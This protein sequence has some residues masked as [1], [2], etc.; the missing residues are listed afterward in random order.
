MADL[1]R[2]LSEGRAGRLDRVGFLAELAQAPLWVPVVPDADGGAPS[3]W[4]F[5]WQDS[6][7][8]A[9]FSSAALLDAFGEVPAHVEV[10]GAQ[11]AATW[12][13]D[14]A[15][16]LDPGSPDG[17]VLPGTVVVTVPDAGPQVVAA[18][19]TVYVGE[20]ASAP[21]P[22]FGTALTEAAQA[23]PGVVQAWLVQLYEERLGPR[24]VGGVQLHEGADPGQVMP[25][26][27]EAVTRALPAEQDLDLVALTGGL[28]AT[29]QAQLVPLLPT[30]T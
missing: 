6:P 30:A 2:A 19:S 9:A 18:G 1:A 10:T 15:L 22:F 17:L 3:L 12:S 26:L 11:L 25:V 29:A 13:P 8:A 5:S 23:T 21:A 24:L 7:T 20:P 4:V 28:L 27:A 14:L 16:A